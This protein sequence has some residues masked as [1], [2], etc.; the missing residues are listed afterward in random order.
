[1]PRM[2]PAAPAPRPTTRV[3]GLSR[4]GRIVHNARVPETNNSQVAPAPSVAGEDGAPILEGRGL[5]KFYLQPDGGR[6]EVISPT[7]IEI[8]PGEIVALLGPSDC[9]KS[10]LLRILRGLARPSA[11]E[12]LWHGRR[13]DSCGE[14]QWNR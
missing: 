6:I 14:T 9:G 11:G 10:T 12:V 2:V 13:E 3:S 5:E 1:M 4:R 8:M 7:N